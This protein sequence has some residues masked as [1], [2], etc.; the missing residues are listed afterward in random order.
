MAQNPKTPPPRMALGL[1]E[2]AAAIGLHRVTLHRLVVAGDGPPTIKL[3][4]RKLVLVSELE[5]W[6]RSRETRGAA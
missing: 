5:D 2:A 3:G 4:R 1:A 6:L